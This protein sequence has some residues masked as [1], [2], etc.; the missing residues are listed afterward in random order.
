M[1]FLPVDLWIELVD[2]K[3]YFVVSLLKT[4]AALWYRGRVIHAWDY[5]TGRAFQNYFGWLM[6][7]NQAEEV[8]VI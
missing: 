3:T 8:G 5:K 2:N 4:T 1:L 6:T 7:V